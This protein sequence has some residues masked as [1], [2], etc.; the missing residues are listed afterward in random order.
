[1]SRGG[2]PQSYRQEK[3]ALLRQYSDCRANDA[4]A[5]EFN[6]SAHVAIYA[7]TTTFTD[8]AGWAM[9]PD[10]SPGVEPLPL[11]WSLAQ[12]LAPAARPKLAALV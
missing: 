9:P 8:D 10:R 11:A 6:R 5:R 2:R 12:L 7:D 4:L 1:M 3:N